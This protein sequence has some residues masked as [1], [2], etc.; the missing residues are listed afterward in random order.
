MS[1]SLNDHRDAGSRRSQSLETAARQHSRSQTKDDPFL[2]A[3][4]SSS[5]QQV[6][7]MNCSSTETDEKKRSKQRRNGGHH[8]GNRSRSS[9]D[10]LRQS[11]GAI[12]SHH[13]RKSKSYHCCRNGRKFGA[14]SKGD[15]HSES[16]KHLSWEEK[17][18]HGRYSQLTTPIVRVGETSEFIERSQHDQNTFKSSKKDDQRFLGEASNQDHPRKSVSGQTQSPAAVRRSSTNDKLQD[19][20]ANDGIHSKSKDKS[21]RTS[22]REFSTKS[23]GEARI[24]SNCPLHRYHSSNKVCQAHKNNLSK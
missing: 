19:D 14:S 18:R 22:Y 1:Q 10:R 21:W 13:H 7:E 12:D 5:Q 15:M 16:Q 17:R 24:V 6:L 4:T 20:C 9:S 23:K 8:S 2:M 11:T 3:A